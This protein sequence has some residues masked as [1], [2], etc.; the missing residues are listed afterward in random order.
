MERPCRGKNPSVDGSMNRGKPGEYR[1]AI[2]I[3]ADGLFVDRITAKRDGSH[4]Q[5][6]PADVT[7]DTRRTVPRFKSCD[8]IALQ[9][10]ACLSAGCFASPHIVTPVTPSRSRSPHNHILAVEHS[11]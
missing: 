9:Q 3:S 1:T 6:F 10:Q 7:D 5:T 11:E 4:R 8:Y 2:A